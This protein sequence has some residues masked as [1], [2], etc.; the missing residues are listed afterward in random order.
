MFTVLTSVG[1]TAEVDVFSR[2]DP[3]ASSSDAN[4]EPHI[5]LGRRAFLASLGVAAVTALVGIPARVSSAAPVGA[6]T[7]GR[8]AL[9]LTQPP[10]SLLGRVAPSVDADERGMFAPSEPWPVVPLSAVVQ[11]DGRLLTFGTP[12]GVSR[13]R[14]MDFDVWDP[15]SGF[16][17]DAHTRTVSMDGY[18][19]FC[20]GLA[21]MSDGRFM[22]VGGNATTSSMMY[23]PATG[24]HVT[25]SR[26]AQPRWYPTVLRLVDDSLIVLGGGEQVIDAYLTP[27]DQSRVA[28]T[29][30]ISTDDGGWRQLTGATSTMAFGALNNHWWYPRAYN[31]PDGTVFGASGDVMWS[32]DPSDGG[33]LVEHGRLPHSIGVSGTSI[34]F[35]PGRIALIGGGQLMNVDYAI[36]STATVLVD[37]NGASPSARATA[38]MAHG[39]HWLNSTMI[40]SGEIL[41][42]GGTGIGVTGDSAVHESEIFDPN[43]ET[44]R[45]AASAT[46]IRTYHST[47]VLMPSGGVFTGGG[48][49]PGPENN[50][51]VEMYY[52]P[53]LF[54]RTPDGRVAWADRPTIVA[55]AGDS[56]RG[57]TVDLTVDH[58]R[59]VVSANLI[60]LPNV[61]H[62]QGVD[63]RFVPLGTSP[64]VS[65]L[66]IVVPD[67]GE[68]PPGHYL[69][70]V[71]DDNGVPSPSQIVDIPV[72]GPMT[73]TVFGDGP[74]PPPEATGGPVSL[75]DVGTHSGH[76]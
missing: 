11:P 3:V 41:V 7:V 36:A 59:P 13:Q 69:L 29:P 49:V 61:T 26:L 31:A 63:Q 42:T 38:P 17:D 74:P 66:A 20:N 22:M 64:T 10:D 15:V 30:E 50:F 27:W 46:R 45:P 62:S 24:E 5:G 51:N 39:R 76:H 2:R 9:G 33:S 44:W 65:G 23:D 21:G 54:T 34:M 12:P 43:T 18:D 71:V 16:D 56:R 57:G 55:I 53:H 6:Y 47:A 40:P 4:F 35:A 28:I 48:G 73:I 60:S 72:D 58:T 68:A 1:P 32:L 25:G 70:T 37:I 67:I 75:D 8:D 14:G 19:A 52:P